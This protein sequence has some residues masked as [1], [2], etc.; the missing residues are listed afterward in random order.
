MDELKKVLNKKEKVLWEG[1][2]EFWPFIFSTNSVITIVGIF[3]LLFTLPVFFIGSGLG[4]IFIKL[5]MLPFILI[6]I[7]L[8]FGMPVYNLFLHSNLYYSITDKRILVQKGV[9]GRDFDMVDFDQITNA[10]VNVGFFDVLF[11]KKTGSILISTAGTYTSGEQGSVPIPY[12]LSNVLD[13]YEVFKF[14]KKVSHD[15]KTDIYYPNKFRP[16]INPGYKTKY[17]SRGLTK[18]AKNR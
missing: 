8:V 16:K 6:G 1:K 14:F 7:L 13:P 12:R 18:K 3:W 17:L 11:G 10:E 2:P 5:V 4:G 9:V 15:V